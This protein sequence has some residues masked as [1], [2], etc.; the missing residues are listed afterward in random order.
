MSVTQW[1]LIAILVALLG[2]CERL[3]VRPSWGVLAVVAVIA[4]TLEMAGV[5]Q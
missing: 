4:G 5:F 3:S 1:F 2:I